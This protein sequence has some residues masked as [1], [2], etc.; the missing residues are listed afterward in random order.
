MLIFKNIE[1]LHLKFLLQSLHYFS[2]SRIENRKEIIRTIENLYFCLRV[3]ELEFQ[4]WIDKLK[5]QNES[6]IWIFKLKSTCILHLEWKNEFYIGHLMLQYLQTIASWPPPA[7]NDHPSGLKRH[8]RGE[9]AFKEGLGGI[10][11]ELMRKRKHTICFII[12]YHERRW[13]LE[14]L[15]QN[16][17]NHNHSP[18]THM[19]SL[20]I[21]DMKDLNINLVEIDWLYKQ[22]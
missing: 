4:K 9:D 17:H 18:D 14:F 11:E 2:L 21:Y 12:R 22:D 15:S 8:S 20:K 5:Y 10:Q 16:P 1:I 13:A 19:K 6:Q 7:A 3:E